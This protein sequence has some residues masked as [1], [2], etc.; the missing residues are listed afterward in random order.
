MIEIENLIVD[1]G[2]AKIGPISLR[3]ETGLHAVLE[4]PTGS[5]KT[6]IVEA[7]AGIRDI[8]S[9]EIFLGGVN[10]THRRPA[11]RWVGYVPQDGVLFPTMSV[12]QNLA[13]GL[14]VRKKYVAQS[15]HIAKTT[16]VAKTT[17]SFDLQ[18][19][20]EEMASLLNISHLLKRSIDKLSGGET[21][22]V[23]LGRALILQPDILLMD[24]PFSAVDRETRRQLESVLVDF[25]QQFQT[26]I[27][28]VSHSY[29]PETLSADVILSMESLNSRTGV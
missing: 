16:P 8:E 15:P 18:T 19:R 29:S 11:D 22:R 14:A 25:H 27:L 7:I 9:G 4:G 20:V 26:T 10:V 13:F 6:T 12:E 3:I 28:H 17:Q 21:Q 2:N 5:G 24:E 1:L 23:A